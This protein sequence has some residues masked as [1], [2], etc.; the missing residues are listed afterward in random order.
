M[1]KASVVDDEM[2]MDAATRMQD[3]VERVD[4]IIVI[5]LLLLML[6]LMLLLLLLLLRFGGFDKDKY[7]NS[8]C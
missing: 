8:P 1:V 4:I 7:E 2:L 5:S 6:M 3:I